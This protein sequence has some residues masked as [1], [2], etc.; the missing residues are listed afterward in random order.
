MHL[1]LSYLLRSV[2]ANAANLTESTLQNE[3]NKII[4]DTLV[5]GD[6]RNFRTPALV[7]HLGF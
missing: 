6:L 1:N 7:R 4:D 2:K 3:F 5:L